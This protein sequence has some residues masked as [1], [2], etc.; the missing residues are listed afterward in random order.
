MKTSEAPTMLLNHHLKALRL[1]VFAR[2]YGKTANQ[3]GVEDADY[4]TF[5]LR[6]SELELMERERKGVERRI[7][8]A[9]FPSRKNLEDFDFAAAPSVNRKQI[10]DLTRCEWI[11]QKENVIFL[12]NPGVGKSHLS[13]ALG[14]SACQRGYGVRMFTAAGLVNALVE[15]RNDKALL[16][17]QGVLA[18]VPLIILDELGYVPFSKTGAELLFEILSQRYER[19]SV[20]ITSN[21]PFEEWTQV[22]SSE[23]LTGALLDRLTHRVHI[24]PIQGE[25]FRLS[26]SKKRKQKPSVLKKEDKEE[27][28]AQAPEEVPA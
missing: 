28:A 13:I 25:S 22:F 5:L 8:A 14:M 4:A 26:Q 11:D 16:R 2:E 27:A 15:A 12:G 7:K 6:L 19:G 1:P 10:V 24:V 21:L 17:L 20:I 3:C 18:K 9:R 23:R